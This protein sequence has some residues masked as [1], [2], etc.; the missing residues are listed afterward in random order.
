MTRPA[1]DGRRLFRGGARPPPGGRG[2]DGSASPPAAE[3]DL[4]RWLCRASTGHSRGAPPPGSPSATA[5]SR[6]SG[7]SG[8]RTSM[9][10]ERGNLPVSPLMFLTGVT[11][12]VTL[13]LLPVQAVSGWRAA[14]RHPGTTERHPERW[15]PPT[16]NV[17]LPGK[18]PF[19]GPTAIKGARLAVTSPAA[20]TAATTTRVGNWHAVGPASSA[21]PPTTTS[22]LRLS[23]P[24]SAQTGELA[25]TERIRATR[26]LRHLEADVDDRSALLGGE[27]WRRPP[28]ERGLR[29]EQ[30][31][32]PPDPGRSLPHTCTIGCDRH[33]RSSPDS[34]RDG[35]EPDRRAGHPRVMQLCG[36]GRTARA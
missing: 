21:R 19:S 23:G 15:N 11:L 25:C 12:N 29:S 18:R 9:G 28:F 16:P 10:S 33:P 17:T 20:S 7:F 4:H 3:S 1:G 6:I 14:Q 27:G 30:A 13:V 2:C 5:W 8:H 36:H 24:T 26:Q 34:N 32:A 31:S 35:Q 22:T